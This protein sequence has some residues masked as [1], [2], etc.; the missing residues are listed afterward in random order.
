MWFI[1]LWRQHRRS[2]PLC[3]FLNQRV[4]TI[5]TPSKKRQPQKHLKPAFVTSI[6]CPRAKVPGAQLLMVNAWGNTKESATNNDN[7]T[8]NEVPEVSC[9]EVSEVPEVPANNEN[10]SIKIM[11]NRGIAVSFSINALIYFVVASY[12]LLIK[13]LRMVISNKRKSRRHL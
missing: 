4:G 8:S 6:F 9:G 11:V 10:E 2:K 12:S 7:D 5:L 13:L 1:T 3:N